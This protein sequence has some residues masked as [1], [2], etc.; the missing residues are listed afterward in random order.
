MHEHLYNYK[1]KVVSVHDGDTCT[2]D[3]DLGLRTWVHGEKARLVRIN[4]PELT[5]MQ[6][7][8]GLTARDFLKSLIDGKEIHLQTIKD[9]QEGR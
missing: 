9:R 1:A 6:K 8:A 5:G 2:V 7:Q 4:T 3:I